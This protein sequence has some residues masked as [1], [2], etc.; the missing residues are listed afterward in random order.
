MA[1]KKAAPLTAGLVKSKAKPAP[2]APAAAVA[3]PVAAPAPPPIDPDLH[4]TEPLNF[5]V[6]PKFRREFRIRAAQENI[7]LNELLEKSF[8]AYIEHS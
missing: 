4:R 3:A 6:S 2:E 8:A 5:R 7:K 1:V